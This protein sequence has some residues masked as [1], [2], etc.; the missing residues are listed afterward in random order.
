MGEASETVP[1]DVG[2]RRRRAPLRAAP[3]CGSANLP[4]AMRDRGIRLRWNEATGYDECLVEDRMATD[5]GL[6]GLGNAGEIF[7]D[8]GR[9]RHY[10]DL[11]PAGFDPHERVKVL[12]AEGIDV[13]VMYPGLG[14]K[15]GA[16]QDPE[17]A[18]ASCQVYN[19]WIAEWCAA[20]ARPAR[21]RRRA[22]DAG[23]EAR[24]RRGA[25]HRG[26]SGLTAGFARPNAYNDRHFHHPS[27]TPVW[28]ALERDRPPDRVPS[29]GPGRHA[30]ARR[31]R[32]AHLMAPGTHHALILLFDQQMTL[33]NLVYGGVLERFPELKVDRARVRRRLDRALDGPARRVPRE[34]RVGDA[35]TVAHADAST[36]S[37]SAG[38]AS[39]PASAPRPR[40]GRSSARDRFVW[41]SDFPHSDAKYPGRGRR[42]AR[43]HRGDGSRRRAPRAVRRATRSTMYGIDGPAGRERDARPP[44][45][46]RHR[47]RRHR[48]AGAHR[49]RRASRDGPIVDDRPRR[50][51]RATEAID[52]DGLLVTPGFVDVHTHYDAQLHWDPTAS[53]ASWHGVTTL[54]TGNCGFTLAPSR[55]DDVEWLL[56][57]LSRVEGMSADALAAGVDVPR[58]HARRLPRRPRR[59]PRRERRRERRA[60][61]G[62][63]LRDGRRRVGARRDRRRDRADAGA[64]ARRVRARARSASRRASSSCT[65]R[66]TA[67]ACRATTRRPTSSIALASVLARV[68]P[69]LDRVHPAHV[70][71]RLRR[72]RPRARAARWRARRAGRCTSTR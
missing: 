3:T 2:D 36:S 10:E 40:S 32:S 68:R 30:R 37:G 38:S 21:R 58:R 55:P 14:L 27:Y 67:A 43:A 72:R 41:A 18:V 34:L 48:R 15:L 70:P 8:F 31:A 56:L 66:T 7:A 47:R 39:I 50:R 52:A 45:P 12:D 19:D 35:P 1:D 17:L 25:P 57:M 59:P 11:N 5:R 4:A 28:E 13:S 64:R 46:R 60:L 69:R 6:V 20:G 71:R 16:I 44:D 29:R 22:P 42:A 24:G 9:G 61:R 62:A 63:P 49:R 33:S 26:R 65:S 54:L 23:P 51:R 53:P